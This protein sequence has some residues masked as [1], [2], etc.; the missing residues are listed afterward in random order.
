MFAVRI[1]TGGFAHSNKGNVC[2]TIS[3]NAFGGR[4]KFLKTSQIPGET[5]EKQIK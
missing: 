3:K 4:I 2:E 1:V 5:K